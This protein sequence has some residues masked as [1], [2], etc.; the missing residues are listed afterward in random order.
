MSKHLITLSIGPVQDFIAAARRTRDLWFGSWVLSEISKA[1]AYEIHQFSDTTLI[2][3]SSNNPEQDLKPCDGTAGY[4]FNVGNK[5]LFLT[6][7]DNPRPLL[8]AETYRHWFKK[9][10]FKKYSHHISN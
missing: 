9:T 1:A 6:E 5:L 8:E 2:F 7:T 10:V 4:C 3:P